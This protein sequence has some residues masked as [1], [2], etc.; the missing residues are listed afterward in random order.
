MEAVSLAG[1]KELAPNLVRILT[2]EEILTAPDLEEKRVEVPEWGGSVR[3][4]S[5]TK[6]QQQ[7]LRKAATVGGEVDNDYLELLM[8]VNGV[9]E[10][11]FSEDQAVLLK[12]KNAGAVDRVL[13]ALMEITGLNKDAVKAAEKRF[14]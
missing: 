10:P 12:D 1:E 2:V 11:R 9:I 8:F 4:R 14:R 6:E 13:K 7:A 5:F 3:I